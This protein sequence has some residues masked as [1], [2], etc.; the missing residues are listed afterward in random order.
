VGRVLVYEGVASEQIDGLYGKADLLGGFG[1]AVFGGVPVE[2]DDDERGGDYG[3]GGRLSHRQKEY[4][5]IG[6]SYFTEEN[7]NDDFREEFGIDLWGSPVK[8]V[9]VEGIS[10]YNLETDGWMEHTYT[11]SL[12]PY[13]NLRVNGEYSDVDYEHFFFSTTL[14]AFDISSLDPD[15]SVQSIGGSAEFDFAEAFTAGAEYKNYGYDLSGSADYYGGL[16]RYSH[17]GYAA[18]ASL[19]RMDG[20][21]DE[22]M[23]YQ[24]RV[25]AAKKLGKADVTLDLF[26]VDYDEEVNDVEHA[27]AIVAALGYNHASNVRAVVD[28]E[29]AENPFFDNE[30]KAFFKLLLKFAGGA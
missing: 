10:S 22:L 18:G 13:N 21:T 27:Y 14:S 26:D 16:I 24:Y 5:S 25:Y 11:L 4:Y 6:L 12:G 17:G 2:T 29:Y 1:A 19:H 30:F 9:H 20:Q 28:V 3:Y 23:Y 15:E 7:D 8:K